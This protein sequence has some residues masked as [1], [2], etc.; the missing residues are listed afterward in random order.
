MDKKGVVLHFWGYGHKSDRWQVAKPINVT[1]NDWLSQNGNPG[2]VLNPDPVV[3][4]VY[5][6]TSVNDPK[7][8][9][10]GVFIEVDAKLVDALEW[11]RNDQQVDYVSCFYITP[12]EGCEVFLPGI[13]VSRLVQRDLHSYL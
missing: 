4:G 9:L 3:P 7:A 11:L 6:L 2:F 12:D 10:I 8:T 1:F 13:W 5:R